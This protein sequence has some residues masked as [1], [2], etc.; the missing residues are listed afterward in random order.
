MAKG[1]QVNVKS[2]FDASGF[3]A[4]VRKMQK[5]IKSSKAELKTL[6]SGFAAVGLAA[7][8]VGKFSLKAAADMETLQT[9][10]ISLVHGA[11]NAAKQME[12]LAD[13]TAKTP[14]Q[15]KEVTGA[16]KQ[17]VA[18]GSDLSV[19]QNELTYLGNIAAA[20]GY[21]INEIA[22]IYA[23]VQA[24]GT[25]SL[26]QLNQLAERGIPIF[27]KLSE[28]TGLPADQLG[29]GAVTVEE[30][31]QAIASFSD[32]GE[33]AEDKMAMLAET[34]NGKLSTAMDNI[35]LAA[36]E[37]G[38]TFMPIAKQIL[39]ISISV[40]DWVRNNPELA[41]TV[42][43]VIGMTAAV[44]GLTAAIA[45]VALALTAVAPW[46]VGVAAAIALIGASVA[47]TIKKKADWNKMLD[48]S[49]RSA[50]ASAHAHKAMREEL[51]RLDEEMSKSTAKAEL[52]LNDYKIFGPDT[53]IGKEALE[54]LRDLGVKFEG[55]S[56][57]VETLRTA[58]NDWKADLDAGNELKVLK[59]GLSD[60]YSSFNVAN[61]KFKKATT[62]L[63]K[64]LEALGANP[65][66]YMDANGMFDIWAVNQFMD[67]IKKTGGEVTN[68]SMAVIGYKGTWD[69]VGRALE[70]IEEQKDKITAGKFDP[71]DSERQ[72][73]YE[74]ALQSRVD[75]FTQAEDRIKERQAEGVYDDEAA[76]KLREENLEEYTG[77][78][79]QQWETT[80]AR[81]SKLQAEMA[82]DSDSG[83]NAS[84][85][86]EIDYLKGLR[87][88]ITDLI[89]STRVAKM[90]L[91]DMQEV[92]D[93]WDAV[94]KA[95]SK[96]KDAIDDFEADREI[97]TTVRQ[98]ISTGYTEADAGSE[99]LANA[100][101]YEAQ[102]VKIRQSIRDIKKEMEGLDEESAAWAEKQQEINDLMQDSYLYIDKARL[103]YTQAA[104]AASTDTDMTSFEEMSSS[105]KQLTHEA[106]LL[107]DS[108]ARMWESVRSGENT[109][110]QLES[111]KT[112]IQEAAAEAP[113]LQAE[114]DR[115]QTGIIDL[116]GTFNVK[117][118][119]DMSKRLGLS[120]ADKMSA[121][122]A[123]ITQQYTTQITTLKALFADG[124]I[125]SV[126]YNAAMA[127]IPDTL[128]EVLQA[129]GGNALVDFWRNGQQAAVDYQ[130]AIKDTVENSKFDAMSAAINAAA[131]S[132]ENL[133]RGVREGTMTVQEGL[134]QMLFSILSSVLDVIQATAIQIAV[135]A[136]RDAAAVPGGAAMAPVII[137][138]MTAVVAG[139]AKGLLPAFAEGGAVLGPTLALV[140]EKPGSRGEAIVPFEKIGQFVDQVGGGSGPT[141]VYVHGVLKGTD[142]AISNQKGNKKRS[143]RY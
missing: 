76:L 42:G 135:L 95:I 40:A 6:A 25:V 23:K 33:F 108:V 134:K 55:T 117:D 66:D 87:T 107:D 103:A 15:L 89:S 65:E 110:E 125:D 86:R 119:E 60:L 3:T 73:K 137:P 22:A 39:D 50:N 62:S 26:K 19:V 140:G 49:A 17:L 69:S 29:A 27:K 139:A 32:S 109:P 114:I 20:S 68:L 8:A 53:D 121:D 138:A 44:A 129:H 132:F 120:G 78:L 58:I 45:A 90:E 34:V 31:Q 70:A 136:A 28:V 105:V 74:D 10:L 111:L 9:S 98:Q 118:A 81:I 64:E 122:I 96:A 79:Q 126:T 75:K 93:R 97:T 88:R 112:A 14:F 36:A 48:N 106:T 80:N 141:D 63:K 12:K 102:A 11:E 59:H 18:S 16:F 130:K 142:I 72:G 100:K 127:K 123:A 133:V 101:A 54:T 131:S 46:M 116:A 113:K 84:R 43:I 82:D 7:A 67:G 94:E 115:L 57:K 92:I 83:R 47:T 124:T 5:S 37:V 91:K 4:G 104:Q 2:T 56:P 52:A 99:E 24:K 21:S 38:K 77:N 1:N 35:K 13:F 51:A 71:F 85:Q 41:K 143:R 30:F 61:N 128:E